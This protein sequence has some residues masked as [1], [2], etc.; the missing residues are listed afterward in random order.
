MRRFDG[1][2]LTQIQGVSCQ[3]SPELVPMEERRTLMIPRE[4][5]SY[6]WGY[7]SGPP[8]GL[9]LVTVDGERVRVQFRSGAKILREFEWREPGRIT[10]IK[11]PEPRPSVAVT[12]ATIKQATAATLALCAWAEDGAEVG[13]SLNGERVATGQ[14]GPT[15]RNSNAFAGEK[16]ISIPREKLKLLRLDNAVTLDN[17]N[18]A[19]FGVGHAYLDIKFV[20]GRTARTA[21]SNRFLF[22]ATQAEG[23]S[24]GK[25]EGWRIIP[26]D[27]LVSVNLGQ[28]L[29]PMHLSFRPK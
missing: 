28:S 15:M 14:L 12:E 22:S 24:S 8:A 20:D 21:V 25:T 29:G 27:A 4:E 16:R 13:V 5:L 9:F 26:P 3:A 11:K 10:D 23:N 18:R 17:P 2:T 19:I 6:Y 1:A 7:L